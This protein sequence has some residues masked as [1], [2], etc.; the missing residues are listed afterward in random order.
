[1]KKK[2]T[3]QQPRILMLSQ[4]N[5]ENFVFN[6][7]LYEFEDVVN[8]IDAVELIVPEQYNYV[9]K[10]TQKIAKITTK[11]GQIFSHINPHTN[12]LQLEQEYDLF[13]VVLDFPWNALTINLIKN[14][15][16]KCRQ[17]VCYIS[18]VW[19]QDIPQWK[20]ALQFLQDFD[21][22]FLA[23]DHSVATVAK[24]LERPC[25]YLPYSVDTLKFYPH[26]PYHQRSIDV[27]NLGRRSSLTHQ[28]LLEVAEQ[29]DIFYYFDSIKT[30]SE[31]R[32]IN[33]QEHRYLIANLIKNSR[34]FIANYAKINLTNQIG[35]YQEIAVRFFEGAAA[36]A[37]MLGTPPDND[38][39]RQYF[40]WSDAVIPIPFDSA[41]I[42]EIIAELDAQPEYLARISR[43]NVINS[44][45]KHDTVYRWQ[46]ILQTIG[47][48][49]SPAMLSRQAYLQKLAQSLQEKAIA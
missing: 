1:M 23:L 27:C 48:K 25:T 24:L 9:G 20:H 4:R 14:W 44:L 22:I 26:L 3:P 29:R 16:Q 2:S 15:R 12:S 31:Q 37:V 8:E 47:M 7:C 33:L 45:L 11:H 28:A 5:I 39:F 30:A 18:E 34:Y 46:E 42:G 13:F 38:Q 21:H 40:N 43:N 32:L 49:P 10:L 41:N 6:C 17:A 35:N 36:G 19:Q